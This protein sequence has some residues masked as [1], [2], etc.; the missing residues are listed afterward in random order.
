MDDEDDVSLRLAAEWTCPECGTDQFERLA[1][2]EMSQEDLQA[3]KE[4]D[5]VNGDEEEGMYVLMPSEVTC[6][7]C[8]RSYKAVEPE[9]D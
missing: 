5:M 6:D 7:K 9:A 4:E 2:I 8:G 3:K 1:R